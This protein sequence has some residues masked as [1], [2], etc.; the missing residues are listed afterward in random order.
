MINVVKE[1]KINIDKS[2][3]IYLKKYDKFTPFILGYSKVIKND[4]EGYIDIYGNSVILNNEQ[5]KLIENFKNKEKEYKLHLDIKDRKYGYK[6]NND[7][8]VIKHKYD[9]AREFSDNLACVTIERKYGFIDENDNL[10]IKPK[11]N[12]ACNFEDGFS[13]VRDIKWGMIDKNGRELFPCIASEMMYLGYNRVYIDGYMYDI[14][15]IKFKHILTMKIN[16]STVKR[17]FDSKIEMEQYE[18]TLYIIVSEILKNY[19]IQKIKKLTI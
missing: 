8:I 10:V 16:D 5:I 3:G 18:K 9:N 2:G 11:Y 7:N 12:Y 6:D 1:V 13:I 17:N 19:D 14:S 4:K 15:N